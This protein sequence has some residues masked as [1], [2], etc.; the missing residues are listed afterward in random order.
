MKKSLKYTFLKHKK[1]LLEHLLKH[2]K[3]RFALIQSN[4][5]M[6]ADNDFLIKPD[7]RDFGRSV[8]EYCTLR[9][10]ELKSV[11]ETITD[12]KEEIKETQWL[13][14]CH[15]TYACSHC[16]E[17]SD[18]LGEIVCN[19]EGET[20]KNVCIPCIEKIHADVEEQKAQQ[21]RRTNPLRNMSSNDIDEAFKNVCDHCGYAFLTTAYCPECQE[22][23]ERQKWI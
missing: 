4:K 6:V 21:I 18:F 15:P 7:P 5:K 11:S 8:E 1:E 19:L 14:D 2:Q 16:H 9:E 20:L 22:Y 10:Q 23:N 13:M 12:L 3:E 17:K